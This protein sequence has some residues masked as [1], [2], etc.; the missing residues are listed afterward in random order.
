MFTLSNILDG[1]RSRSTNNQS[2]DSRPRC[3]RLRAEVLR[4]RGLATPTPLNR[5]L[6]MG[7]DEG[8]SP[9]T[10]LPIACKS[11]PV[12]RITLRWCEIFRDSE[13]G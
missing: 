1:M 10:P 6:V 7:E 12:H 2:S 4:L 13:G 5:D 3:A 9:P 8:G 11:I